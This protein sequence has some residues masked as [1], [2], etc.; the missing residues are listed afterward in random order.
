MTEGSQPH[1]APAPGTIHRLATRRPLECRPVAIDR[2]GLRFLLRAHAD[3]VSFART[4]TLGRLTVYADEATLAA[5]FGDFGQH[6]SAADAYHI[7]HSAGG[8]ADALFRRLGCDQLQSLDASDYQGATIKFDLNDPLPESL[9]RTA[10]AVL[11]FGT[12]EHIFNAPRALANCME[13]VEPQGH[14]LVC[15]PADNSFGHG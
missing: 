7:L 11:D 15:S 9:R 12:L 4:T 1:R 5:T 8:F 3:G 2:N 13:M 10:S 6:L 14:L